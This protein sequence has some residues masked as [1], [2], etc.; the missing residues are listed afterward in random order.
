MQLTMYR[1]SSFTNPTI[2]EDF[3]WARLWKYENIGSEIYS[4]VEE[5]YA[6]KTLILL[7]LIDRF[8]TILFR[9]PTR[10]FMGNKIIYGQEQP[11]NFFRTST[12]KGWIG[13]SFPLVFLK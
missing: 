3:P 6:I 1:I 8:N 11:R 4:W 9:F 2:N 12:G 5:I 10:V 13:H 7:A